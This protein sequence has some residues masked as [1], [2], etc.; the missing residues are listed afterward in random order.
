MK[1][2]GWWLLALCTGS[3]AAQTVEGT[4]AD[5][6]TGAGI[7]GARVTLEQA[8]KSVYSATS[9]A[10]GRFR[11]ADVANG[12]Y[13]ARYTVPGYFSE[14]QQGLP[15]SF[16]VSAGI[17]VTLETRLVPFARI[18]GRVLDA[19]GEGV[20]GALIL[21]ATPGFLDMALTAAQGKFDMGGL[22][23]PGAYRLAVVPL[24]TLKPPDPDPETVQKRGWA[25]TYYPGVT[26]HNAATKLQVRPGNQNADLEIKLQMAPAH[27]LRGAVLNPDGTPARGVEVAATAEIRPGAV[28]KSAANG[29]FEL[30]LA[31]GSWCIIANDTG[32]EG[33]L[34]A[35]E[36]IDMAGS[37]REALKLRLSRP[38]TLRGQVIVERPEGTP[39]PKF[40]GVAVAE[41]P[42]RLLL[43]AFSEMGEVPPPGFGGGREDDTFQMQDLYAG[44]YR[45]VPGPAPAGYYLD[46][47]RVGE[48]EMSAPEVEII[49]GSLPIT[50]VYK[51]HGGVVHGAAENCAA[52][53]VVLVPADAALRRPGFFVKAPC[54]AKDRYE[55]AAVRPGDYYAVA[56]AGNSPMPWDAATFD[57]ALLGQAAR[58]TVRAGESTGADL[59]AIVQ[60]VF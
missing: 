18:A 26:V 49:S 43:D 37:D 36:W 30:P 12:V 4:V 57:D 59:Q 46:S 13:A 2:V 52:G 5:S 31:D 34:R 35:T 20:A 16:P 42:S 38:F 53:G 27:I 48:A 23:R 56:F 44:F 45:I 47:I 10:Q 19:H 22:H 1:F 32:P 3:A 24:S 11:I 60:P 21:L 41:R 51:G 6:V 33:H 40:P 55:T 7:A 39:A 54:D 29:S 25:L 14:D 50:L 58:V 9:D 8:G 15:R 17:P 28:A